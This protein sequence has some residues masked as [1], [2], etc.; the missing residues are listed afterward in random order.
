MGKK[1]KSNKPAANAK[2][3]EDLPQWHAALP[4][5]TSEAVSELP[6][7]DHGW[8][9]TILRTQ[10]TDRDHPHG[11]LAI[12]D[13]TNQVRGEGTA[14][15]Y[16]N[17]GPCPSPE[18]DPGGIARAVMATMVAPQR[19]PKDLAEYSEPRR[20]A[21]VL[22]EESLAPALETVASMLGSA[23]VAVQLNT[24]E[25]LSSAAG[26]PRD[27]APAADEDARGRTATWDIGLAIGPTVENA[28]KLDKAEGQV[29]KFSM[30]MLED[31]RTGARECFGAVEDVT[32][33]R[34]EGGSYP[35]GVGPCPP[36]T[37]NPNGMVRALLATMLSPRKREGGYGDARRPGRVL[38]DKPLEPWLEHVQSKLQEADVAVEVMA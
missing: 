17:V 12:L 23:D 33:D 9:C 37:L 6:Q 14:P 15:R 24:P 7:V 16:M 1:S 35:L 8:L 28:L 18:D 34:S 22:L 20:P 32:D 2:Q 25:A 10:E 26:G 19:N 31:R 4:R 36:A 11:I 3:R 27:G 5:A 38:L 29:W 13:V 30:T 21:W